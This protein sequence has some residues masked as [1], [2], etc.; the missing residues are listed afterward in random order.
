MERNTIKFVRSYESFDYGEQPKPLK[1]AEAALEAQRLAARDPQHF[2]RVIP[3]DEA[4]TGFRVEKVSK[5]KELVRS[6]RFHHRRGMF[7]HAPYSYNYR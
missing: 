3:V 2:Y 7:D 1:L 4:M 6:G 5:E